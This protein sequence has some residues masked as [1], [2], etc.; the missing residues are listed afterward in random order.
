MKRK[1]AGSKV[2]RDL[3]RLGIAT[4][5]AVALVLVTGGAAGPF[6][7]AQATGEKYVILGWNNLG[8]HCY[9]GDFSDFAILPPYNTLYAQVIKIGDPPQIVSQG[10]T[11]KYSFPDNTYSAGRS[12]RP[13][14]TN[15]WF[16]AQTLFHLPN[17]LPVNTGLTGMKL[18]GAMNVEGDHFIAEGIPLT[19]FRDQDTVN[20]QRYPYQLA[21][22]EIGKGVGIFHR[23][24]AA[25]T[26]VAPVSTEI[27]CV[28]CHADDGDATGRYPINPTGGVKTNILALHDYL[29]EGAYAE[30]L[31]GRRPVLC[32]DCHASA[33]LGAPGLPGVK[34]LSNAMHFHHKDLDDITPDTDGCY[35]CHP[36]PETQCLRD[37][38]SQHFSFNCTDCHGTMEVVAQNPQPWLNEPQ[39]ANPACHGPSYA[40]DQPLY[41][42]SR[43]HAGVF[44]AGC[45]DSPHAIAPSREANDGIKFL[46]LQGHTGTLSDCTVCHATKP[47]QRFHHSL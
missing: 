46:Q 44:C 29:N 18:F 1:A 33:A 34:S 5:L 42:L 38:M 27:S 43:G 41:R 12:G 20:W 24:I 25:S 37:T 21:Q 47:D 36:G 13:D 2:P 8:M 11:V 15:F 16:F 22:L 7:G 31:M 30:P 28:N 26:V 17:P 40:T 32:A 35:N 9:D 45:H 19:E 3:R 39:C 6:G 23:T 4:M 14:K 10:L